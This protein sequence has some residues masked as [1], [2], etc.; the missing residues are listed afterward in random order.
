MESL[1]PFSFLF[2]NTFLYSIRTTFGKDT[3]YLVI[4]TEIPGKLRLSI[5]IHSQYRQEI[6]VNK[7]A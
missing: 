5:G 1:L 2:L 4:K 7:E 3:Q 6:M